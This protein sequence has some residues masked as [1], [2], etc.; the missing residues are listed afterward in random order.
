MLKDWWLG[1]FGMYLAIAGIVN[2]FI[3]WFF[4]TAINDVARAV[5]S[6]HETA[7]KTHETAIRQLRE[8]E[9]S[10]RL[11]RQLLRAYN[12]EPEG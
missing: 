12:F 7:K 9:K 4:W 1:E 3:L 11:Q 10:N 2:L 8:T 5:K 6:A